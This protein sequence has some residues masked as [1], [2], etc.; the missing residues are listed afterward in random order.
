M[1]AREGKAEQEMKTSLVFNLDQLHPAGYCHQEYMR[2]SIQKGR[3]IFRYCG[4]NS[5]TPTSDFVAALSPVEQIY[6]GDAGNDRCDVVCL[7][8]LATGEDIHVWHQGASMRYH[9]LIAG[10]SDEEVGRVLEQ[11]RQLLPPLVIEEPNVV[12]VQFWATTAHG[13]TYRMR[14]LAAN[15]WE[16][17]AKN[18]SQSTREQIQ[19]LV[20]LQPP[21][22]GGRILLWH[23]EPGTGKSYGI[24]ALAYE[25]RRWCQAS[26]VVDPENFFGDAGYMMSVIFDSFAEESRWHLLIMEDADEFLSVDAKQRQ[27]QAMSRLLNMADGLIGQGLNLLLLITTNEPL[28][29]IHH[30]VSRRGRCLADVEFM[31]LSQREVSEWLKDNDL[32]NTLASGQMVLADLYAVGRE[33]TVN[34]ARKRE[35]LGFTQR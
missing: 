28:G 2:R 10:D 27:G 7:L 8:T 24:R 18:Y 17:I 19:K 23:G 20:R 35:Q 13:P 16:E 31:A 4:A 22:T 9:V 3:T 26:F 12:P 29:R 5:E 21:I 1:V 34:G 32:D 11:V 6:V 33:E 15:N 14:Q 30:A 25:W